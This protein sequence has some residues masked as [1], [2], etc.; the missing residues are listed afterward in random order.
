MDMVVIPTERETGRKAPKTKGEAAVVIVMET[1]LGTEIINAAV[2]VGTEVES[3]VVAATAEK[4]IV[5]LAAV[6]AVAGVGTE[7]TVGEDLMREP[8]RLLC[9]GKI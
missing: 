6:T 3:A 1:E 9:P 4:G 7:A 5:V 8:G 2:G